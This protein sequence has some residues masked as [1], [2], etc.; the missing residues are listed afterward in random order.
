VKFRDLAKQFQ[1][2]I[3]QKAVARK[4]QKRLRHYRNSGEVTYPRLFGYRRTPNGVEVV[5]DQAKCVRLIVGLLALGRLPAEVKK[6]MD[7]RGERNGSGDRFTEDEIKR[8]AA[9]VVYTGRILTTS[10]KFVAS[11]IYQPL[12]AV[13]I[14]SKAQKNL[15]RMSNSV[16]PIIGERVSLTFSRH[17]P[18]PDTKWAFLGL[19]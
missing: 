2:R 6:E 1:D 18:C 15:K 3:Q 5:D 9:K 14:W 8:I 11:K 10:G 16:S 19:P 13:E 7:K 4:T 12:I 17:T